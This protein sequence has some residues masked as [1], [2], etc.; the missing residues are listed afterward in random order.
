MKTTIFQKL[1]LIVFIALL[2]LALYVKKDR[3]FSEQSLGN[4]HM[5]TTCSDGK[6]SYDEMIDEA[7]K[8]GFSFVALT[9]HTICKEN[10]AKCAQETR[11][12]CIPGQEVT[13][14]RI[15][16]LALNTQQYVNQ[17]IPLTKQVEKIH[18]LGG[19]A[20]AAHP[21]AKDFLY[22][23][24]E[25]A[26]SGIDAM[27]CTS[28]TNERRPLPCVWDSDAH[29]THDLG[30]QFMSCTTPIKSLEDIKTAIFSKKCPRTI[31]LP[32]TTPVNMKEQL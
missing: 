32:L 9:D 26:N 31:V 17:H 6:N 8:L 20:I 11:I 12:Y 22:T 2:A 13:G 3:I 23:D 16:L 24:A 15:H 21:N 19:L 29:N 1:F 7:V 5:H 30:W 27:E 25:L 14:D 28:N 4:L 18:E 10:T